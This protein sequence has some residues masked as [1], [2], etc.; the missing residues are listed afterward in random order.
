MFRNLAK[1]YQL[2]PSVFGLP[3]APAGGFG[4]PQTAP[5][6]AGFGQQSTLGGGSSPFGQTSGF[7]QPPSVGFGGGSM[8]VSGG[9]GS[10]FGA[11]SGSTFGGSSFGALAQSPSPSP[12]GA[13]PSGG[14]GTPAPSFGAP[15]AGFGGAPTPFGAPR[16]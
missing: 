15:A 13:A 11:A 6:P 12:F 5:G 3:A 14:F 10:T 2:D 4:T 1:K 16:R 7:G 8:G 9:G